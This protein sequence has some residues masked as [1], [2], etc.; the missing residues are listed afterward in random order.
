VSTTNIRGFSR[1]AVQ[2]LVVEDFEPYRTFVTSLLKETAG[3]QV[4]CEVGD[5]LQAVEK[6]QELNPDLILL[7]IGMPGLN[8][9]EAARQILKIKPESKIIF[10]TQETTAEVVHEALNLG[11]CGYVVKSQAAKE[12]LGAIEATLQGKR[13]ISSGLDGHESAATDGHG[14]IR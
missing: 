7:D 1:Q 13:F 11:A 4:I 14:T 10:L 2:I 12:L 5:G 3:F 8:G 6:A 9:I